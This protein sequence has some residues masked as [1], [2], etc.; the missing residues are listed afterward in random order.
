MKQDSGFSLLEVTV[1][2]ALFSLLMVLAYGGVRVVTNADS[3]MV[4]V[5]SEMEDILKVHKQLRYWL[6]HAYPFDIKRATKKLLYPMSGDDRTLSFTSP[7]LADNIMRHLTLAYD[8]IRKLIT[9]RQCPDAN[10]GV[11]EGLCRRDV[12]LDHVEQLQISYM[13]L[14]NGTP[15]WVERWQKRTDLPKAVKLTLAF[16]QSLKRLWPD[17][18]VEMR[19]DDQAHCNFDPVTRDCR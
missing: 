5:Q 17:L 16:E 19:I 6:A 7:S 4:V 14:E 2:L 3:R 1:A 12:F 15:N 8:P 9:L 13:T 10:N 11:N 18:V